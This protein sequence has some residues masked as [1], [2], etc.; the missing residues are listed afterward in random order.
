MQKIKDELI[1]L[2]YGDLECVFDIDIGPPAY[3]KYTDAMLTSGEVNRMCPGIIGE[4]LDLYYHDE[5]E[6]G[7]RSSVLFFYMNV[8]GI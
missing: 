4:S 8:V 1:A 3:S 2:G 5:G 7:H 6:I